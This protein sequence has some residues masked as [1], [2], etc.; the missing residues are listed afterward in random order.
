M[1]LKNGLKFMINHKKITILTKKLKLK[2][3]RLDQIYV[4]LVMHL[5][6]LKEILLLKV[7][8]MLINVIKILCLKIMYHILITS[9]KLI[10]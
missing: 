5:L 8:I 4:I 9:Q 1:L 6:L 10:A 2:H 7:V 3:Q